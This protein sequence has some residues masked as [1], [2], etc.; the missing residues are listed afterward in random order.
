MLEEASSTLFTIAKDVKIQLEFNP[1]KVAEYRLIGY[2]SRA[3]KREDFN[4]DAVDAGD[5]GSGHTL[6]AIY[7]ITPQGSKGRIDPSRYATASKKKQSDFSGEYGFVKLRY[8]LPDS[9]TSTLIS[10]AIR[11]PQND[12]NGLVA[13]E[14]AWATAVA[15]F[16]QLLK[17]SDY[18]GTYT[19][20]T[21]IKLALKGKGDD[22]NGYR[23]EF[24]NLVRL[25][26]AIHK[27]N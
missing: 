25:A 12:T 24:I 4:N 17:Q 26:K 19:Y 20:D 23:A 8:K 27:R 13:N 11:A 16:A 9:D 1:E 5:I 15:G 21:V 14:V 3:L 7:E 10:Q 6:T 22:V 2:E 18:I